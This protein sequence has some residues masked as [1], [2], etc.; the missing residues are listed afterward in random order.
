MTDELTGLPWLRAQLEAQIA[1]NTR[2]AQIDV[3]NGSVSAHING[4]M[5][6]TY[7]NCL[8]LIDQM[9]ERK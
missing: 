2:I 6:L 5:A 8:F 1:E 4:V 3:M 7:K 9:E